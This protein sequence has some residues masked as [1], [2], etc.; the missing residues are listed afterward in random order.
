LFFESVPSQIERGPEVG[1]MYR[2]LGNPAA[3]YSA[4]SD[5]N[6]PLDGRLRC[7]LGG[8]HSALGCLHGACH[9]LGYSALCRNGEII[10]G[11]GVL[12][13][14]LSLYVRVVRRKNKTQIASDRI[15]ATNVCDHFLVVE[16]GLVS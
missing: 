9:T 6:F 3:R 10:P 12:R 1:Y 4:A 13:C 5:S 7:A 11:F 14:Y 15:S 16:S 8:L 2:K